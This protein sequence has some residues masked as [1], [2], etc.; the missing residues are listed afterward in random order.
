MGSGK[1]AYAGV[2]GAVA[3]IVGLIGV[4][5]GWFSNDAQTVRGTADVSGQLA[6]WASIGTFAFGGAYVVLSDPQIRRAMGALMTIS[7]VILT[8]GVVWGMTRAEQVGPGAD[9]ATG[10]LTSALGGVL[11]IAAGL[12]ALQSS[13]KADEEAAA[14]GSQ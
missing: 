12:L 8:I 1:I 6:L 5:A 11:G 9:T 7:A 10:L 4:F 14:T 13:M 3:G 2:V